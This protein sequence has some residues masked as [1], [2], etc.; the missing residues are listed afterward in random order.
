MLQ[1]YIHAEG[2]LKWHFSFPFSYITTIVH[3]KNAC[4]YLTHDNIQMYEL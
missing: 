2:V 4:N 3:S 1:R